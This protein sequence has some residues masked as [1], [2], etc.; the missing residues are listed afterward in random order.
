M[1]TPISI[2][3]YKGDP[4][5]APEFRHTSLFLELPSN[6]VKLHVTGASGFFQFQEEPVETA[7]DIDIVG[8]IY[9][10]DIDDPAGKAV[11]SII[12]RTPVDNSDRSWNCQNWVGDALKRLSERRLI[13]DADRSKAIDAMVEVLL[14]A[15]DEA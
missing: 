12:S 1:P 7:E 15:P 13:T 4:I 11:L 5:D 9:V 10:G 8:K 3:V 14:D 6:P 2:L